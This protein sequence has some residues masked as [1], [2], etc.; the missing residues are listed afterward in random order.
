MLGD[1]FTP[2]IVH[3]IESVR[4]NPV[5]VARSA[6][7][8]GKTHA[9]AR[10]A[11]W[12]YRA[13]DDAQVWT[14]A[15]PENNLKLLLWGEIGGMVAGHP[16]LF[17][18]DTMRVMHI[19]RNSQSFITGARISTSGSREQRMAKFSGKHAPHLLF[20]VDEGD[21]VPSEI[22]EAIEGCMSGGHARML[23]MFNPRSEVGP[24]Y[25]M[26]QERRANVV[27]LSAL[28]HPNVVTGDDVI[29]GCVSREVVVRRINEW[30]RPLMDGEAQDEC[31]ELPDFLVGCT[32]LSLSGTEY[33]PLP[34]GPRKITDPALSYMVLGQYPAQSENQL[35]SRT[36]VEAAVMRW[37]AYVAQYGERPPADIVPIAGLDVADMG[38]DSNALCLRYG[39]YVPRLKTWNGVD[40][41]ATAIKAAEM[42]K[43]VKSRCVNVDATGVGAGVAPRMT[44]L[45]VTADSIKVAES[46]T[47]TV[48]QGEFA[49]LRDQLWW[50]AREWLRTDPGAM[51]PPD[52]RLVEGLTKPQYGKN[53][54]GKIK[55]TAKETLVE[56]LGYSPDEAD[57]LCLTFAP[58]KSVRVAFV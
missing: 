20:I 39:G 8:V 33:A 50:E 48:E 35:I 11:V 41:D 55:V 27:Q 2:D 6:V 56:Q 12:F 13:F 57:A 42:C 1:T 21:T 36:W 58:S 15:T 22:Y 49:M 17:A 16:D 44:R 29:P 47:R 23:V 46:P 43:S 5:T 19:E 7:D 53:S 24:V 37:R 51:L 3:V 14:T 45:G 10:V 54:K 40:P 9:A 25:R 32:A 28:N 18:S 34:A 38:R 30:S 26:E 4:D 52:E 31:F